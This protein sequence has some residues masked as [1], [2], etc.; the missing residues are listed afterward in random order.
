MALGELALDLFERP[1]ELGKRVAGNADAAVRDGDADAVADVRARGSLMRPPSGV[2]FTAL[3]SRFSMI[4]LSR[5][6]SALR[7]MPAV[8]AGS[9][10]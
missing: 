4:C 3:D 1:A 7:R 6:R 8:D 10:A 5:R 2:N 9:R